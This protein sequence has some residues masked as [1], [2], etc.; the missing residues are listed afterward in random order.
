MAKRQKKSLRFKLILIFLILLILAGGAY[1]FYY[2]TTPQITLKGE[3]AMEVTM[4]DGYTEPGAEATFSFHDISSHI[5]I[6]ATDL[7]D[8]K[9]GTYTVTYTV[10]YLDKTASKSR[11]VHV[12]DRE[13]P[14]ITLTE[15]DHISVRPM[16]R[17]EDPGAEAFDDSD[18]DVTDEIEQIVYAALKP[19]G[20]EFDDL[21]R[22][23]LLG[24]LDAARTKA[25]AMAAHEGYA[26]D[27]IVDM[28][29]GYENRVYRSAS[30][31]NTDVY[32]AEAASMD[33][34]AGKSIAIDPG[35][36]E[37]AAN[38]T[39]TYATRMAS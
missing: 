25:D 14:E 24:A 30:L 34:A 17:F 12:V 1:A 27:G 32:A 10:D 9:V 5:R 37:I 16:S 18:G 4:K 2:F 38:V 31:S 15:G 23:A 21:Y 3:E 36:V 29:E 8:H 26:I 7:N 11:T 19:L 20:V 6:D 35:T 28:T 33:A 22:N 13:P 39:V